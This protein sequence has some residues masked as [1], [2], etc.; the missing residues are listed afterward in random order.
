M[1]HGSLLFASCLA[2]TSAAYVACGGDDT[3]QTS[4]PDASSDG[5]TTSDG[6]SSGDASSGDGGCSGTTCGSAACVD[7]ATSSANCGG[8]GHDCGGG[9]CTAGVCQPVA[10]AKNLGSPANLATLLGG[11]FVTVYD[12]GH[13]L[14]IDQGDGGVTT[15]KPN[16]VHPWGIAPGPGGVNGL[17]HF[18][19]A[20]GGGA[21]GVWEAICDLS[22]CGNAAPPTTSEDFVRGL[23]DDGSGNVFWTDET[24]DAGARIRYHNFNKGTLI[25]V[26]TGEPGAYGILYAGFN[27]NG[28]LFFT[29]REVAGRVRQVRRD[30]VNS[31]DYITN[32]VSPEGLTADID[33]LWVADTG[34]NRIAS[35]PL[36]AGCSLSAAT[37]A[38]ASHPHTVVVDADTV[39]WTNGENPG[40]S[41]QSCPKKGCPA[42]GPTTLV[43]GQANPL[44]LLVDKSYVYFTTS[45]P[46]G[47]VYRVRKP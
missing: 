35:C 43:S 38:P 31:V 11:L 46:G 42:G 34:G 41:I 27:S 13:V 16:V 4:G 25:D 18:G 28:Y 3:A 36:V 14:R 1:K 2:M 20:N 9:A 5:T 17:I 32:L 15:I 45:V 23:V 6:A 47:A 26:T 40:G 10:L 30:G 24:G 7:L 8:C 19:E 33:T 21:A 44:G 22:G 29:R 39:Y 37:F 12:D